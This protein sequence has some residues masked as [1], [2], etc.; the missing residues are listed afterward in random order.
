MPLRIEPLGGSH[1]RAAFSCGSAP[2][3]RYLQTQASQ[4]VEKKLAAVF[5]LTEDGKTILGYYTL[6]S[7]VLK[8]TDIPEAIAKKL[9][10]MGDVPATLLGRLARS[11]GVKGKGF[12]PILLADALKRAFLGSADI[13]SW[14]VVVDAK[15]QK[16]IDFYKENGFIELPN[17]PNR[18]FLPMSSIRQLFE[19]DNAK[20]AAPVVDVHAQSKLPPAPS[21]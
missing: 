19:Q 17:T 15:D 16:A 21:S 6:S 7:Y 2:L 20:A 3:D 8:L 10:K 12:G 4:A 11:S 13:A 18:L 14:A 5:V 1:D 9:T